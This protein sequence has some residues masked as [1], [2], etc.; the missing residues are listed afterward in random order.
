ML[1]FFRNLILLN[2]NNIT[3]NSNDLIFGNTMPFKTQLEFELVSVID[4]ISNVIDPIYFWEFDAGT[5]D[6]VKDDILIING[7]PHCYLGEVVEILSYEEGINEYINAYENDSDTISYYSNNKELKKFGLVLNL[8][9][10]N[11]IK[12]VL[13]NCKSSE[14]SQGDYVI[15]T[16]YSVQ[17]RLGNGVL[18]C[19]INPL[20]EQLDE[21]TIDELTEQQLHNICTSIYYGS[22]TAESPSIIQREP[23]KTPLYTGINA[24]DCFIPVGYGQRE[25]IIGDRGTGKT[26]LGISIILHTLNHNLFYN[27]PWRKIEKFLF[28]TYRHSNF[29]ACVYVAIGQKRAEIARLRQ[30]LIDNNS[31]WYTAIVFTAAEDTPAL[32]Y[33]APY[34]GCAIGEFFRDSGYK[35][36]LIYDDLSSHAVAYRQMAL[37]LRRPP[38]REAYPGDV[39]YIHSRLLERS[40]QLNKNCGGGALASFPIIET[41][42][43]DISAYIAT[44][45][46]SIT[47]GQIYLS[48]DLANK[49]NRPAVH[50]GLSVS[51]V[52][53]AAQ[54]STMKG[55]ARKIKLSYAM[56][57]IVDGMD[58]LSEELDPSIMTYIRR[59]RCIDAALRQSMYVTY[60]LLNS[61]IPLYI[62]SNGALDT[63]ELKHLNFYLF[64]LI[65]PQVQNEFVL[66]S[67]LFDINLD[68]FIE[69]Y[70]IMSDLS[71]AFNLSLFLSTYVLFAK[72]IAEWIS[73]NISHLQLKL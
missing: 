28:N 18:G 53:S 38:G 6:E 27:E 17:T 11:I 58:K 4:D 63:L 72:N 60:D 42:A 55:I 44:N 32:Q 7:M 66:N 52:G 22:I 23:V 35:S 61:F 56:Y 39:F 65:S 73:T 64:A 30:L 68:Q 57:K 62:I 71:Y 48:S 5:I 36:I 50:L 25:L 15:R 24:V 45:V 9:E 29:I 70:D 59:G 54:V 8:E 37:L 26:S 16:F 21:H 49:G 43:G 69:S 2:Q 34:A 41:R 14:I 13:L 20:G 47:D 46:I 1:F 31:Y 19:M 40:A 67:E 10:N 3:I 33:L 12:V 51:R